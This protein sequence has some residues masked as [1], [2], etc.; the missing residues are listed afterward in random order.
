MIII[1]SAIINRKEL[2][3]K[4]DKNMTYERRKIQC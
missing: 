3:L 4:K 2:D 1:N